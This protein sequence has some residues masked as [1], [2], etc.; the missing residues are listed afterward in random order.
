MMGLLRRKTRGPRI[1]ALTVVRDEAVMLPRWI[2]YYGAQLG[3]ENL[4][5]VDDRSTDGSTDD[6]P[7]RVIPHD[8]FPEGR[9]ET[10]R[11]RLVSRI[12]SRLLHDHDAVIF[13]DA[14]EFLLADPDRYDGLRDFVAEHPDLPVAAGLGLNVVHHL[15][16]EG[17]LDPDRPVLGQRRY[18]K[19]VGKLCK[20][21]LKRVDARWA[22]ASHG[23]RAPY[24]PDRGLL[25]AHLKFADLDLLRRTA[26][27]RHAV[28]VQAGLG[29][30][31]GW[32][33]SGDE[34]AAQ[35]RSFL[36][37]GPE[38]PEFDPQQVTPSDLVAHRNGV[39]LAR[40]NRQLKTMLE[41]PLLRIPERFHGMV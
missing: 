3:N 16:H 40:G 22:K 18:A 34:I 41:A 2:G 8:G 31:S 21:S 30:G 19:F 37:G 32:A 26:D 20:P 14:D 9:F 15:D 27:L 7:C 35:F 5:V 13:T 23:I 4:V 33:Q 36:N 1:A 28:R 6:L 12:A 29:E 10:A 24:E 11:M 17:P 25:M 38:V 39:W